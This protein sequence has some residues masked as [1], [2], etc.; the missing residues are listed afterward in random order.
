MIMSRRVNLGLLGATLMVVSIMASA[1]AEDIECGVVVTPEQMAFEAT[2]QAMAPLTQAADSTIYYVPTTIHVVRRDNGSGGMTAERVILAM[3]DLNF[4]YEQVGMRFFRFRVGDSLFIDYIDSDTYYFGTNNSSMWSALRQV[5]VVP[6]TMNVYF[7]P[8][9]GLCGISSFTSSSVQGMIVDNNCAG[10]ASNNSTFAHEVGHY[11]NLYHTHETAFGVECPGG[12]NCDFAGDLLCDTQA[13]PDLNGKVNSSTC[14][15]IGSDPTP[16]ECSPITYAPQTDLLLSYSTKLCRNL[17]ST[18]QIG[19]MRLTLTFQRAYLF[20]FD[21]ADADG[22]GVFDVADNCPTIANSD[23]LDIDLDGVG[24]ICLRAKFT[25]VP[26]IGNAP[27][28]VAFAG[29]SNLPALDWQWDFGDGATGGGQSPLH[30]YADTG[31]YSALMTVTTDSGV[32]TAQKDDY[33]LVLADSLEGSRDT[34]DGGLATIVVSA[35]NTRAVRQ[36]LLPVAWDVSFGVTL[37]SISTAGLRTAYL[38]AQDY[39]HFDPFQMQMTFRMMT[40]FGQ[41]YLDPGDGPIAVLYFSSTSIPVGDSTPVDLD[42]Y[43]GY[44]PAFGLASGS[45]IPVTASGV[46]VAPQYVCGDADGSGDV[47]I[48]DAVF[49]ISYIF[50]GGPEPIPGE[51]GNADGS[52]SITIADVVYIIAFIFGGGPNPVC[53]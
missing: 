40:T 29:L 42:G 48:A 52:G 18:S 34:L 19:K 28:S 45:N 38:G 15:Y 1:S 43:P 22:D 39:I 2:W 11:F 17:F 7:C 14:A 23:Q 3:R 12:G 4:M 10:L 8:N 49:L 44:S 21:S 24:D 20:Q 6:N 37:D 35:R 13:D 50:S 31:L 46:V 26:T 53:P 32:F 47:T 33:I 27:M 51:A 16:I 30:V 9:T 25:A 36:I 5:N 41:P